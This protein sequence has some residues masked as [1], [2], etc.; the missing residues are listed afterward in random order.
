MATIIEL[1]SV[2]AVS[3]AD[4]FPIWSDANDD[5]RRATFGL[6]KQE[7]L[8][9]LSS[10]GAGTGTVTSVGITPGTGISVSG[11]P[12][13]SSG[14]IT[15]TNTAPDQ[16]V[17]LT[18]GAN[19]TIT[20]TYPNFTIAASGGGGS[21]TVTTVSVVSANG[22]AGTVANATTTP[23][24]TLTT[25]ITGIVKGNGTALSAASAGTDYVAPGAYTSSGLTVSTSRILGRTTAGTGAAEELSVGTGLS[26]S[27]GLL[28]N[29]A[30]DQTVSFTNGTG[31]SVTGTY[32]AFT[33]TNSAPMAYPG[34]GIAVS[35]GSAWG[36][37]LTAPSGTIVGTT[38]TQT[39]TNKRIDPRV[40]SASSASSLTPDISAADIYAYTALAAALTINAP[41]GTPVNGDKLMF[42]IKDNGGSQTL[43]WN[44]AFRAIGVTLPTAT[45]ASKITYVGAIYNAA[46][47]VWD[48]IAAVTQA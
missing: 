22:F 41:T 10:I 2:D 32:P 8:D 4:S 28:T 39:L 45:T 35:T 38:D 3:D 47:S 13:T 16:V 42:R 20:G 19:V 6:L 40:T 36:T 11:S 7:L 15:V 31:I 14:F 24:I 33:V 26:L 48:V 43:T 27:G 5:A 12:I 21:G 25:S 9:W 37:S 1:S 34:A 46:E 29:S 44:A 18:A 23:A 17:T 30:P